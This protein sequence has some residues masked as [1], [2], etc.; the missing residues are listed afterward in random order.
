[1]EDAATLAAHFK[2]TCFLVTSVD[3]ENVQKV[4]SLAGR[5]GL[6]VLWDACTVDD[7]EKLDQFPELSNVPKNE[8]PVESTFSI[9]TDNL[10]ARVVVLDAS[11]LPGDSHVR[12]ASSVDSFM[13]SSPWRDTL[14]AKLRDPAAAPIVKEIKNMLDVNPAWIGIE[15]DELDGSVDVMEKYIFSKCF[16]MVYQP[17]D[18]DDA[19]QDRLFVEK[20]EHLKGVV[21]FSSLCSEAV[22]EPTLEAYKDPIAALEL[23]GQ[24][25]SPYE[26]LDCLLSFVKGIASSNNEASSDLL[27][28]IIIA[29]ITTI[30]KL[31]SEQVSST[32]PIYS[33][34][35]SQDALS[36]EPKPLSD[37]AS[38]FMNTI[39][40][41]PRA[42]GS[43]VVDT[44]RSRSSRAS[45]AAASKEVSAGASPA[46]EPA[47]FAALHPEIRRLREKVLATDDIRSLSLGE[48]QQ[49]IQ[50]Y[51]NLLRS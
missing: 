15:K 26:K 8:Y 12:P 5:L 19:V 51:R 47:N 40:F 24:V 14:L 17:A 25:E 31:H 30:E 36:K 4:V 13:V 28:P 33:M 42:I 23:T 39:G 29:A 38:T 2:D 6:V 1:M 45:S 48:I 7:P 41:V 18:L 46:T 20:I 49:I 32:T 35:A 3:E 50:D 10:D 37:V 22:G 11:H 44:F 16:S 34:L 9:D 43:A 21:S 27:I